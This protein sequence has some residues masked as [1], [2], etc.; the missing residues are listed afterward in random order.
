MTEGEFLSLPEA[1]F[2]G[3]KF[4][5][6]TDE[7]DGGR[8]GPDHEFPGKDQGYPEDTGKKMEGYAFNGYIGRRPGQADPID[9]VNNLIDALNREGPGELVHPIFGTV[10]V[11]LRTWRKSGSKNLLGIHT[12]TMSFKEASDPT[13]PTATRSAA[14][15]MPGAASSAHR[16]AAGLFNR[17]FAVAGKYDYLRNRAVDRLGILGDGYH[18]L[19]ALNAIP[20]D[21]TSLLQIAVDILLSI[22]RDGESDFANAIVALPMAVTDYYETP[23]RHKRNMDGTYRGGNSMTGGGPISPVAV[24]ALSKMFD[25]GEV[26]ENLSIRQ[27]SASSRTEQ[28]NADALAAYGRQTAIIE[29]ARIAPFIN[30]RTLDDAEHYRDRIADALDYEAEITDDDEVYRAFSAMRV[31]V[32]QSVTPDDGSLPRLVDYVPARTMPSLVLAYRLYGAADKAD[33]I[34]SINSIRHPGFIAG[35]ETVRVLSDA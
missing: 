18:A 20:V 9:Q 25:A 16:T 7:R 33:D 19:A 8:R 28:Q 21:I 32:I 34:A 5:V 24:T 15:G 14:A 3:V 31:L 12:F 30:W 4:H 17:R 2:R 1:S 29:A 6:D 13:Y 26:A 35:A 27:Y 23:W 10:Q 11:Q 22:I